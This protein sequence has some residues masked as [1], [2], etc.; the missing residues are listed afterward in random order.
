MW[1]MSVVIPASLC[2]RYLN[3]LHEHH[4]GVVKMK[5]LA[6]SVLWWPGLDADIERTEKARATCRSDNLSH[7]SL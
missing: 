4:L 6:R 3:E 5:S 7:L 2:Q 1:G